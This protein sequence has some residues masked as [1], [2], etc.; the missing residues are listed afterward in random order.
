MSFIEVPGPHYIKR[1]LIFVNSDERDPNE[2]EDNFTFTYDLQE[3]LQ[4]VFSLELVQ[5]HMNRAVTPTLLGQL[6]QFDV[7]RT[8]LVIRIPQNS[9]M[10]VDF[11]FLDD[12]LTN[13]LRFFST[14][15][16]GIFFLS[17]F[18]WGG[19]PLSVPALW[20]AFIFDVL[21]R[22]AAA[23]V[24]DPIFG[25]GAYLPEASI[26][27]NFLVKWILPNQ[28]VI[29]TTYG[30]INFLFKTGPNRDN[31]M[32]IPIGFKPNLDQYADLTDPQR[33][34]RSPFTANVRPFTY[35]DVHLREASEFRPWAR[36][37]TLD[38]QTNNYFQPATTPHRAR[39]LKAPIRNMRNLHFEIR[40]RGGR[41][42]TQLANV[43][44]DLTIE[45]LSIA[46]VP[47][48]PLWV[49]QRLTL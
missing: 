34:N 27:E 18:P 49:Q 39:I 40:T 42:L 25:G 30:T 36:I 37:Y 46:Q 15:D 29:P 31:Q 16:P 43:G 4:Q 44:T 38:E 13:E 48:V 35:V 14:L 2:S 6:D 32:S 45:A 12:T 5:Y 33:A 47:K 10:M 20:I 26:D 17:V 11:L 41:K 7:F 1:T 21:F 8:G 23:A 28:N 24:G 22:Y 3:G 19:L 9:N